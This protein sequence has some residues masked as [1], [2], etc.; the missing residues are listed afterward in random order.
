M[1]KR[2]SVDIEGMGIYDV[3][4]SV[5]EDNYTDITSIWFNYSNTENYAIARDNICN[6]CHRCYE[7]CYTK[8]DKEWLLKQI[9][10]MLIDEPKMIK[11]YNIV[12][13]YDSNE[14]YICYEP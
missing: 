6:K 3:E 14:F 11:E 13:S 12:N 1:V 2:G 9:A 5:L 4:D 7:Y 8:V 10:H